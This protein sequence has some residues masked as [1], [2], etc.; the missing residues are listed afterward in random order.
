MA[1]VR[2]SSDVYFREEL[3][4]LLPQWSMLPQKESIYTYNNLFILK[5]NHRG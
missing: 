4:K 1:Q 2:H 3:K 5:C